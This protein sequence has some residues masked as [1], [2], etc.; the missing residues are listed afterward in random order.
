MPKYSSKNGIQ[1][2]KQKKH[3]KRKLRSGKSRKIMR[4][5]IMN[6][7][8]TS[9]GSLPR[10]LTLDEIFTLLKR[11]DS[12]RNNNETLKNFKYY[13]IKELGYT[14]TVEDSLGYT[15]NI[16]ES[17][18]LKSCLDKDGKPMYSLSRLRGLNFKSHSVNVALFQ[19]PYTLEEIVEIMFK[20]NT[21]SGYIIGLLASKYD[22]QVQK[23]NTFMK[24]FSKPLPENY[25]DSLKRSLSQK[26]KE[27]DFKTELRKILNEHTELVGLFDKV[28]RK[29]HQNESYTS[30]FEYSPIYALLGSYIS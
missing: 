5:G 11:Y 27:T 10:L 20:L 3:T 28:I 30:N 1:R 7:S 24:F 8:N 16:E 9:G 23:K 12:L 26:K 13:F 6:T 21:N 17:P 14:G 25:F 15:G 19:H 18:T 4:G 2:N 29:Y 22:E